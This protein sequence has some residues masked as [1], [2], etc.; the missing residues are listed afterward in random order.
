MKNNTTLKLGNLK[1]CYDSLMKNPN[2]GSFNLGKHFG[3]LEAG[4]LQFNYLETEMIEGVNS[5][6]VK[7]IK[8]DKWWKKYKK[9]TYQ[10]AIIRMCKKMFLDNGIEI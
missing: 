8:N 6:K 4:L 1:N 5:V 10:D 7:M 2:M 9:E 3:Y